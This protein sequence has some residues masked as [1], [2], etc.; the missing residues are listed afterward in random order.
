MSQQAASAW[1]SFA[2]KNLKVG[3]AI[4]DAVNAMT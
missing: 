1:A 3:L 4:A 2:N